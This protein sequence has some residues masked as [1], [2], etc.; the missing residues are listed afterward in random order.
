MSVIELVGRVLFALV[1]VV[2]P[3]GVLKQIQSVTKAPPLRWLPSRAAVP[4][5]SASCVVAVGGAALVLLGL[6]P[7]LGALLILAFLIPVTLT[8]HRFWE[9]ADPGARGIKRGLFLANTSLA[10]GALLLFS[11]FN[12]TQH[13][14][15][16]VLSHPLF[17]GS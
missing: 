8:M 17:G 3:A 1:F 16:A 14:P 6:W 15:V 2:S 10:G 13:V 12:Q 7:D 9:V 5:V 4:I 11:L